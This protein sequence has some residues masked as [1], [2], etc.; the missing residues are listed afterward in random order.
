[1]KVQEENE[2]QMARELMGSGP[3]GSIDG[4]VPSSKD[5]FEKLSKAITEKVQMFNQSKHYNDFV[6]GLIKDLALDLPAPHLK[7]VKIHVETLHSTKIKEQNSAKKG[8][9]KKGST[10]KMDL[11]KDM[12]GGGGGGEALDEDDFM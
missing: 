11:S 8:K 12:F 5:D 7:Q 1:L 3:P 2:L 4:M 6:E 10:V 9:G